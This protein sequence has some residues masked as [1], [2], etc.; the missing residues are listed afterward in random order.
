MSFAR[1]YLTYLH[2]LT[3]PCR[4]YGAVNNT[5][6]HMGIIVIDLLIL[7]IDLQDGKVV[8]VRV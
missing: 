3:H 5:L 1:R 7:F 2:Q 8:A 6:R 4:L